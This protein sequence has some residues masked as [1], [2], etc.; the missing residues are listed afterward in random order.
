[1]H[2]PSQTTTDRRTD[3][4]GQTDKLTRQ[5][6]RTRQDRHT[7]SRHTSKKQQKQRRTDKQQ[8]T[9][10]ERERD[11]DRQRRTIITAIVAR[12][13]AQSV[14]PSS[15]LPEQTSPGQALVQVK[16]YAPSLMGLDSASAESNHL[17]E[18]DFT[19]RGLPRA[20][21]FLEPPATHRSPVT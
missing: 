21:A 16:P 3:Q 6:G 19:L 17:P 4:T 14:L 15:H 18:V 1:M 5:D 8:T 2:W 11:T 10:K 20:Y 9:E 12:R 7:N 13:P